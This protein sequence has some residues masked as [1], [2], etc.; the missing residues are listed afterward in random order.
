MFIF[1]SKNEH[2]LIEISLH[3]LLTSALLKVCRILAV[4]SDPATIWV[5]QLCPL[6]S[7]HT[8]PP[9]HIL[10]IPS[11]LLPAMRRLQ[12]CSACLALE[13]TAHTC[14][15]H[16]IC[17]L[18]KIWRV[19]RTVTFHAV[20]Q[21]SDTKPAEEQDSSELQDRHM[22]PYCYEPTLI[23]D[24]LMK[25]AAFC[26]CFIRFIGR[27]GKQNTFGGW[28]KRGFKTSVTLKACTH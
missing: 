26:R 22:A 8:P 18:A 25:Y 6:H 15:T 23:L 5:P 1:P 9:V 4:L 20:K 16:E 27:V 28:S 12:L 11:P 17:K 7:T 21:V 13:A 10:R 19:W 24:S 3:P 2:F 14:S